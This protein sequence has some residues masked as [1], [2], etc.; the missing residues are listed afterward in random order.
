MRFILY[1][2]IIAIVFSNFIFAGGFQI[3]EH[4]ARATGM[5]GAFVTSYAPISIFYNPAGLVYLK[6]TNL[7]IGTTLIFPSARFR[8]PYQFNTTAE[9]KMVKQVFYPSNLYLTHTFD[10]GLAFGIGVFNPYG[11]GSKWPDNWVGRAITVESDLKTFYINPTVAYKFSEDL[12]IG[13]GF[14]FVYSTVTLTRKITTFN[15]EVD[16][17]LSGD[18]TGMGFNVGWLL[19]LDPVSVGFSYRS[20][21]KVDF[22]GTAD[23]K[24]PAALNALLPGGNIKTSVEMPD[25]VLAGVGFSTESVTLEFAYQ[26]TR[27]SLY[28]VVEIDFEKETTAQRDQKLERYYKDA[29]IY[30]AGLEYR[31][32]NIALRGGI[33]YDR[34]PISDKY[35]EPSLPDSDRWIF[36][37]GAGYTMGNLTIDLG[38]MFVRF[39][40]REVIG[41]IVGFD[42]VYNSSA[43]LLGINFSYKLF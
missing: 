11:L 31:F 40:Q 9:T 43:H 14:N 2:L 8:G 26:F 24:K 30:R 12:S 21:V 38:Y 36:T 5:G 22:S 3:N 34:N 1:W 18:G 29:S 13:A 20:Q 27:W 42:G 37:V 10:N 33:A 15:P 19:K 25:I 6:G 23:F 39:K 41:T 7:S 28:D 17:K 32:E 35:L 16:V 4:G